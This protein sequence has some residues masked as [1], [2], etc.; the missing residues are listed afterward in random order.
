MENCIFCKI[1]KGDI[2]SATIYEDQ[3]FK[4]ILDRFPGAEGHALIL[5]KAHCANIFE[6]DPELC[7]RLY[8]LSA[9]IAPILKEATGCEGMNILQNNGEAAGQTVHHFHVHLIPRCS[10]DSVNI[11]WKPLQLS[12]QDMEQMKQKINI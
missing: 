11:S 4:V 12:D 9:K 5:P 8:Q 2:P 3:E 6:I 7:G 1:I 10:E